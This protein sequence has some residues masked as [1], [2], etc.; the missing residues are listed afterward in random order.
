MCS[1][2]KCNS[3]WCPLSDFNNCNNKVC[4]DGLHWYCKSCR[5][6]SSR[7]SYFRNRDTRIAQTIKYQHT[8]KGKLVVS[9]AIKKYH[10]SKKGKK[11]QLKADKKHRQ[12]EKYKLSK[13]KARANRRGY[14]DIQ[15]FDNPFPNDIPVVGHHISDGFVVYI[16]VELHK[17]YL[18][19]SRK[20]LHR[21]ELKPFIEK[22]YNITYTII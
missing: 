19:G 9:K 12:T 20:Q 13:R 22:I 1:G 7:D 5:A 8:T 16:P 15:L 11:S 10:Q 18:H 2:Y 4:P 6:K 17:K 21:N 3:H 14:D